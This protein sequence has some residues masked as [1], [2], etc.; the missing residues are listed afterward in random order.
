MS[1]RPIV[2][3]GDPVLRRKGA[4]VTRFDRDLGRLLDDMLATM[5]AAPGVG[6]AAQQIGLALQVCV[7]EVEDRIHELIN[8]RLVRL[9]GE[10][11]DLEGCLSL[12]G[13]WAERT[14]AQTAVVEAR[15]RHGRPIR[16]AG[17]GLL[18]R[19]L[20]HELGHLAGELYTD[21]LDPAV[22]LISSAELRAREDETPDG[23]E[24]AAAEGSGGRGP[25]AEAV[26]AAP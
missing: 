16:V 21:V 18:A 10:Q 22:D 13:Y 3:F 26:R 23:P 7:I 19:A 17:S 12:P 8:P 15:N 2:T 11:T 20:Q 4:L 5:R 6:L 24:G 14:R 25:L 9:S 1:I